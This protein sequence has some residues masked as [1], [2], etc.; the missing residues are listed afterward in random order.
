MFVLPMIGQNFIAP[1]TTFAFVGKWIHRG[2]GSFVYGF[3]LGVIGLWIPE[4]FM[5]AILAC[6]FVY[7]AQH[8][9]SK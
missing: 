2:C 8:F 5:M 4:E 9:S 1:G 3:A 6:F 7:F